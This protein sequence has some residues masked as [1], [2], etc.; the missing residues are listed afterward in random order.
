MSLLSK[1]QKN[2]LA[3]LIFNKKS[4]ANAGLLLS[5]KDLNLFL[6]LFLWLEHIELFAFVYAFVLKAL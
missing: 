3:S 1:I 6:R 5:K 2:T 4:P